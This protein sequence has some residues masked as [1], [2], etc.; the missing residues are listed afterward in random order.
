MNT[1][2]TK[3]RLQRS[4]HDVCWILNL[5]E[6]TA[7][8]LPSRRD[9]RDRAKIVEISLRLLRSCHDACDILNLDKIAPRYPPSCQY[10]WDLAEICRDLAMMFVSFWIPARER[11]RHDIC[12]FLKS[13]RV[14]S[15]IFYISPILARSRC[16]VRLFLYFAKILKDTNFLPR[17]PKYTQWNPL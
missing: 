14:R 10:Y 17:L 1:Q 7:R 4:R 13:C 15:G 16:E 12:W 2:K 9:C 11:S 3:T 5:S 8:Y 6:M